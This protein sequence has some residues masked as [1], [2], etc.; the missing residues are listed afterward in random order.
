MYEIN[1]LIRADLEVDEII[2][3][4]ESV[5]NGLG[6]KFNNE[7][8]DYVETLKIF[9]F[10]EEK[11]D[12]VRTLPLKKFPYTIHFTVDELEKTVSIQAVAS[13]HQ[14]PNITRIRI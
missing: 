2:Q 8:E 11:Y 14:D 12:I 7:F 10:F 1:I 13:N 9:P 5:S 6:T 4:Y 3:Y